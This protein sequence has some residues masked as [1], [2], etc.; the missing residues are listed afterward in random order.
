MPEEELVPVETALEAT[1]VVVVAVD[2][3]EELVA[4]PPAPAVAAIAPS[5]E[6][7][8]LVNAAKT[9]GMRRA[10]DHTTLAEWRSRPRMASADAFYFD[11]W[12]PLL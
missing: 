10:R 3:V 4:C 6:Q 1:V 2:D 7:P 9:G 5:S 8:R 11:A 12:A